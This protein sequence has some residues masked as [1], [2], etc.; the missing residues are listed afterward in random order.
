MNKTLRTLLDEFVEQYGLTV[1]RGKRHWKVKH[2]S[3][4]M[5]TI[6]ESP[7]DCRALNNIRRDLRHLCQ[8]E[9]K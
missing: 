1:V 5:T 6:S 3:G 8:G 9:P 7:S 2:P 4:R